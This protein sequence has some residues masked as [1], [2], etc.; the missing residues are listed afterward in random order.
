MERTRAETWGTKVWGR[1][2]TGSEGERWRQ[3]YI[4]RAEKSLVQVWDRGRGK[5]KQYLVSEEHKNWLI[6]VFYSPSCQPAI[7]AVCISLFSWDVVKIVHLHAAFPARE[8]Q[9]EELFSTAVKK[10]KRGKRIKKKMGTPLL[11]FLKQHFGGSASKNNHCPSCLCPWQPLMCS[12]SRSDHSDDLVGN[13]AWILS[14]MWFLVCLSKC[15]W[16][17]NI[18][19]SDKGKIQGRQR[20]RSWKVCKTH[21]T[22][23]SITAKWSTLS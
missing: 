14:L 18:R 22:S 3:R 6:S 17:H 2:L 23:S 20:V 15:W 4:K 7:H 21:P 10:A 8:P 11:Q 19:D 9:P 5:V 13:L 16:Q 12:C 1:G